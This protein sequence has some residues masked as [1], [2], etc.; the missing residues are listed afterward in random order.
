[1]GQA[2]ARATARH[3]VDLDQQ[4]EI[5]FGC[6]IKEYIAENGWSKFREDEEKTDL[7]AKLKEI[8][9]DTDN[10]VGPKSIGKQEIIREFNKIFC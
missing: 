5:G 2:L 4:L 8:I 3:F 9:Y 1:M 7:I 6:T 10:T